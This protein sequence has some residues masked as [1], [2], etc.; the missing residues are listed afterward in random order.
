M[1]LMS[2]RRANY[3]GEGPYS[4]SQFKKTNTN[5]KNL[6]HFLNVTKRGVKQ[7]VDERH[8]NVETI[9]G[10]QVDSDQIQKSSN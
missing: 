8:L 4:F 5:R 6:R 7:K 3:V 2:Y 9:T 10:T 1:N